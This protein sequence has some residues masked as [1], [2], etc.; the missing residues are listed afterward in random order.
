[1]AKYEGSLTSLQIVSALGICHLLVKEDLKL[2]V[3]QVN[4]N[5]MDLDQSMAAYLAKVRKLEESFLN[6]LQ[7]P[8][9]KG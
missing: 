1:M 2:M 6:S 3:Q 9:S 8:P 7:S 4:N 5:Y